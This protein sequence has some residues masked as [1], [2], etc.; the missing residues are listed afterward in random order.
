ML[1]LIEKLFKPTAEKTRRELQPL[2]NRIEAYNESMSM[3]SDADL[4]ARIAE[5]RASLD[6]NLDQKKLQKALDELLPEAFAIVREASWRV[7]EMKHFPCQL[8]GGIVLHQGKIAEMRTGEGKTLVATL[9]TVLNALSGR[10]VHVVT[11]NDYLAKRDSE[12]MGRLYKFL[13]FSVGLIVPQQRS[14]DKKLAYAS[15]IAYATNNELGFDYLR[16]NMASSLDEQVRRRFNYAIIDE[17]DSILIDEART[18]LIISGVPEG[19]KKEIYLVMSALSE[20]LLKGKDKDDEQ[21]DYYVDEKARNV[22]LTDK[23]IASAEKA[24]K[25]DDLWAIESNFAHHLIQAVKAKELFNKD[26]EYV[27]QANPESGKKEIA[28]V[29]EFTGRIMH[30]RRWSDGLHQAIEAKEK[31]AIQEE[32]LTLASVT[33]QNFFRLYPKLAGMTGTASTEAEE[34]KNIYNLPVVPMPTNKTNIRED[35]DDQVYKNEK[36]KFYAIVEEIIDVHKKGRPI[37]V[38][39]TSIDKSEK[40]SEMLTRPQEMVSLLLKRGERLKVLLKGFDGADNLSQQIAKLIDRPL[41]IK[42]EVAEQIFEKALD[43][44]SLAG[45]IKKSIEICL[46]PEKQVSGSDSDLV[47]FIDTFLRSCNAVEEIRKGINHHVLNAKHHEKEAFII[48]QAGKHKGIT[49][50]TNMAGRG[51]DILLGGNA[52]FLAKEKISP[53]KLEV[54]SLEYEAAFNEALE[55]VRSGVEEEHRK[56]VELGGL[57]VIGS[58]RHESRRI[59]NQLRGRAGRQGDPGSTRFFLAL[60]DSLMRIFGGDRLTGAMEFLKAEDDLAIEAKLV[61]NGIENAQ[62]KVESHNYDIRKRLLEYDDVQNTQRKVI[63]EERQRVLESGNT[64]QPPY[65]GETEA[66]NN[67]QEVAETTPKSTIRENFIEMLRESVDSIVYTYLDPSKPSEVWLEKVLPEGIEE[68]EE[69]NTDELPTQLDLVLSALDASFPSISSRF[70]FAKL[71]E[72]SFSEL[73]ETLTEYAIQAYEEKEQELSLEVMR[74]AEKQVL[75]Q[76]IDQ[77]WVEHLQALDA[78]KEGIHLRGYGNKQPLIEYKT[79]ALA[80]FDR[81]ISSIRKQAII[82]I[83]HT[84]A[85]RVKKDLAGVV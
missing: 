65:K 52:E 73:L 68:G 50:A 2:A 28:I 39:T 61:N 14:G 22:V 45:K 64:P 17:V 21:G 30:G 57:H 79:E 19:T 67:S 5:L 7:L 35:W 3:K 12:W 10:G 25:V 75:L 71:S 84:H 13:G 58:E 49:I 56:V 6:P 15:D 9:P 29:D 66:D 63:Y 38:G 62:Q 59:D 37:L 76:S 4:V 53:L 34:F 69:I 27:I 26:S 70:D 32:T 85:V 47:F 80:L 18:P 16:D 36:Q 54:G 46:N 43:D 20:R 40:L 55:E 41:N 11:A 83:F 24:L 51:T 72:L 44:S 1:Q 33:F 23:G 31:V 74:E 48:A 77:H 60:D 78:L 81:L 82:W 8:M 42:Y